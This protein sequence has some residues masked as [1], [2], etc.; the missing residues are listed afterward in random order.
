VV[1]GVGTTQR[2]GGWREALAVYADRR[3]ATVALLGFS[4]GL[5]LALTASTLSLRLAELGIDK[6]TIGLFAAVATPYSL[7]FAWAPIVDRTPIPLL[8]RWLGRRRSWALLSQAALAAALVGLGAS[9]P[10]GNATRTAL[11]A[12]AVATA[13]ATQDIVLDAFRV[14]LLEVRSQGA[15]AGT[16][17]LGYRVGM[18]VA[19]AG[20]LVLATSFSWAVVYAV[21]AAFVAVGAG[22]VLASPEP[23]LQVAA[24]AAATRK[25]GPAAMAVWFREAVVDPFTDFARRPLWL[26]VLLFVVLFKLG[27]AMAGVMTNPFLVEIGFSKLEIAAVV[28]TFGFAATIVGSLAGGALM[29]AVGL[30]RSLWI[31]GLFQMVSIMLFAVQAQ[32]GH[33]TAMLALTIG[34]ENLAIGMGTSAFVAYLSSL[35]SVAYTAT[36]YALLSSLAALAR[37]WLASSA[38]VIAQAT[39][40]TLFFVLAA[41]CALPGLGLLA[42]LSMRGAIGERDAK[43]AG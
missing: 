26:A 1:E 25:R 7:K 30:T 3:I 6:S 12:L 10:V 35:C 22:A 20:A 32:I 37:T 2:R 27:D 8:T 15:A 38:G 13:S 36:Q 5:P 23:A 19:G 43:G 33:S 31:C 39:T 14:E 29:G 24:S 17:V 21:M 16:F 4:S 28:K 11:W 18:L 42:W 34:V 9:D 40:W 41:G